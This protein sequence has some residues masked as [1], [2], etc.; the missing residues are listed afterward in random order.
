ME[1]EVRRYI[2]EEEGFRFRFSLLIFFLLLAFTVIPIR[3]LYV[4]LF[5]EKVLSGVEKYYRDIQVIKI[6]KYRGKIEDREGSLLA[7]SYPVG[8]IYFSKLQLFIQKKEGKEKLRKFVKGLSQITG[9][10]EK[11]LWSILKK[12]EKRGFFEFI[13]FPYEKLE[14]VRALKNS[15]DYDRDK[16]KYTEPYISS[17]VRIDIKY[18]RFY[19]HKNFASNLI[20]F[21]RKDGSGGE[22]LEYQFNEF[23]TG[24]SKAWDEFYVYRDKKIVFVEPTYNFASLPKDLRLSL[25]FRLQAAVEEIKRD[26]VRRWRPKRVVI[27]VMESKTGKIRAFTTYPDYDPNNY[28]RYYPRRTKNFGV[29]ELFEPGSTFKPFVVAYALEKGIISPSS[30]IFINKGKKKIH[31]KILRDPTAYLRKKD[32]ITPEELLVYSSNVGA[33]TIGLLFKPEDYVELLNT[34][35][36]KTTP[37]V[38]V[39]E[40]NPI[41][42][43]L[44]N[45]VNRA[46]LA[47]GQGISLNALHLLSSFNALIRGEFV[48]PSVVENEEVRKEK[49]DISPWITRWIRKTLIKVVEEG[50]GK[51]AKTELFYVGGKTGTAQKYDVRLRRYSRRKLTTYF[52]GFFPEDARFVAIIL[53]DEPK[54]KDPYGGTVAA[55][56]FKRLV[57]KTAVIYNLS[58]ER[59]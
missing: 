44:S 46:Y 23:L 54:G 8:V 14:D 19:P 15:V 25:D 10:P 26:I 16:K 22:G 2:S 49:I 45:E 28:L 13:E 50:T 1:R 37:K 4:N 29:V 12:N 18:R 41:I 36:L 38:L 3:L 53:V 56:Y 32:Y 35:H 42:P 34:F 11:K 48:Y 33:A 5:S 55:P 52:V 58:P 39:G 7:V 59:K 30:S 57:E 21:V 20:G 24:S 51:K 40:Q 43:N 47:I 27:I 6:P 9:I 17:F 31:K